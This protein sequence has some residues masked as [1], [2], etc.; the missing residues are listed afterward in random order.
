MDNKMD[1]NSTYIYALGGL[2]EIGKNSYVIEDSDS[3]VI[4][5]AGIKF[6]NELYSG[7]NGMIANYES[8][9]EKK[10]KIKAL[11]IT[12][13]HEDHIGAIPHLLRQLPI[14]KIIAP[15]LPVELIKKRLS[16]HKDIEP[17]EMLSYSD[18]SIF[19]LGSIKVDFLRVCHSI[20]DSF[21]VVFETPNGKIVESGDFR[22]DFATDGDQTN[23]AKMMEIGMRGIDVLLCEST[24]SEVPGFSESEKYIIKNIEDYIKAA[25]G[26]VFVSTFSSNLSRIEEIIV[27]A[28]NLNKK[29]AIMGKSMEANVKIS[30]RLGYLKAK[31]SD[32][33]QAKDVKN[34][35]DNEVLVILTGS[36]GEPTAALNMMAQ[37]KHSKISLKPSDTVILS[38]N[39]IPGNFAQVESLI[40]NLYRHGVTVRENHPDKKIH[41][42]GHATRSEQQL[43]IRGINSRY[44]VPIHGEYKMLK[45]LKKNATDLGYKED[46]IIIVR[47]GDVLQL[48]DKKLTH[49]IGARKAY[50]P[51]LVNGIEVSAYTKQLLNERNQLSNDGIV[52]V[53]LQYSAKNNK[54]YD[55][56]ISTRGCFY[57]SDNI[58]LL[59]RLLGSIKK[60]FNS[61]I[62]SENFIFSNES[63]N[64]IRKKL[65][66][67]VKTS[68]WRT[69]KKN[70]IICFDFIN[71]D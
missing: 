30:R 36:Q 24:S 4:V 43:L 49:L 8:L 61:Y 23:L 40:N 9:L 29:V 27:I 32:F 35:P 5:D 44:L 59:N 19:Q 34:Y 60:E 31:D 56:T 1:L 58:Q 64:E 37:G 42:S 7:F 71:I 18:D 47:N 54:V 12:H 48:K 62:K 57:A 51:V 11:I 22:F 26:R 45:T 39:P 50:E 21:A 2:D 55:T 33:I 69:K 68:I 14:K 16:E 28:I 63:I 10:E 46:D 53:V 41:S 52:N 6:T 15:T 38:S 20:P 67:I 25:Q 70:P 3:L 65:F 66:E 17:V 13:G